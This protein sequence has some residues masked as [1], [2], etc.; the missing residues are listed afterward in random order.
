ML[1]KLLLGLGVLGF[2]SNVFAAPYVVSK[3]S[4]EVTDNETGLTWKRCAEGASWTGARCSGAPM[5]FTFEKA[6]ARARAEAIAS[7]L[8]WR[9]P[10]EAELMGITKAGFSPAI[11]SVAFPDTPPNKFWTCSPFGLHVGCGIEPTPGPY[12]RAKFVLFA[13][14]AADAGYRLESNYVR[15]VRGANA[16]SA[17]H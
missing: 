3:N 5:R 14:G 6:Q 15:L 4:A 1:L 7:G 16:A 2:G 12:A 11:D 10:S 8:D 17:S 13:N 9:V